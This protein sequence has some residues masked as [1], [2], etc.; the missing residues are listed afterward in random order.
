MIAGTKFG[1]ENDTNALCKIQPPLRL[2]AINDHRGGRR[3]HPLDPIDNI[4]RNP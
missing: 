2:A 1:F 3:Y 4:S